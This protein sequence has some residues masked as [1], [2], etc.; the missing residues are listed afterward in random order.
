MMTPTVVIEAWSNWRITTA[1][2]IQMIPNTSHS[3]QSFES[4]SIA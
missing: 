4:P 1:A 3:H 2:A